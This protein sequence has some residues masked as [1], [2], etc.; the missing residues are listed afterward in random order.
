MGVVVGGGLGWWCFEREILRE[1]LGL[2]NRVN[3]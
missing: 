1:D 3:C 2:S